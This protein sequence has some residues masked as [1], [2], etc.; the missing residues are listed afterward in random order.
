[1]RSATSQDRGYCVIK[2]VWKYEVEAGAISSISMPKDAEILCVKPQHG[3]VFMWALVDTGAEKEER[4]FILLE[5]GQ[6]W[7]DNFPPLGKYV[8]TYQLGDGHLVFHLFE[9]GA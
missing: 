6:Q 3:D 2:A 4:N 5:T 9:G 8:G 7:L 1:M